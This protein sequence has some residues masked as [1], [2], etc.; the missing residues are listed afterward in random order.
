MAEATD[1]SE[2][3][4][5]DPFDMFDREAARLDAYFSTLADDDWARPSRCEAWTVRDVLAHLLAAE[6]Y[7]HA[8][9]DG[10]VAEFD[11]QV[12]AK[13]GT[14][15]HRG[16]AI[17]IA[18]LAGQEPAQ[19]LAEWRVANAETRRGF[20]ERGDG[21][22]DTSV[23]EYPCRWQALHIA[24][25]LATHADD[26]GVPITPEERDA[27]LAWRARVSRFALA[28]TKPDITIS[29]ESGRTR[30]RRDDLEVDVDD[31]EVIEGVAARLD[32]TS[33]LDAPARA[34]L[35]AMP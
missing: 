19:L 35:S 12:A 20:R 27:R 28:E 11:A 18:E 10:T 14:D 1:D 30:V 17:L 8:C 13:G 15:L 9:L 23:G 34:L 2:L 21:T 33:R 25:E 29:V 22:V 24:S 4:G 31:E 16:N 7:F 32:A 26:V 6:G 3:V 5:L